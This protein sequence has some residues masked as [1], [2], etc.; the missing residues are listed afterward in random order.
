MSYYTT[1]QVSVFEPETFEVESIAPQIREHLDTYGISHDVL[2]DVREAFRSGE[3]LVK[4]HGGYVVSLMDWIHQHAPELDFC[5]RGW[6]E[7]PDDIWIRSYNKSGIGLEAGPFDLSAQRSGTRVAPSGWL[8]Q[9]LTKD[10]R[11]VFVRPIYKKVLV[12]VI[13]A[14]VL[15]IAFSYVGGHV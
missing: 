10:G 8:T 15:L 9:A 1:L 5:A 2:E 6:G 13:L 7:W 3:S 4:V 11:G 12:G 14:V